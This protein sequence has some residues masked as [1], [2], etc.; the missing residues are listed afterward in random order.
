MSSFCLILL[1]W[2]ASPR[3][4]S[5]QDPNHVAVVVR[6]DEE[7]VISKCVAFDEEQISGYDA[8]RRS[9]LSVIAGF[10][11]QGGTMCQIDGVG[12]PADNCFCRC[13]G[14]QDC[15]YWSYW[16]QVGD[17]WE[18][19]RV[20]A[21]TYRVGDKQVEGWSWGPGTISQA[22]EPPKVTFEEVCDSL[23]RGE[24]A[25]PTEESTLPGGWLQYALFGGILGLFALALVYSQI[26]RD[27]A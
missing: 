6:F 4:L 15:I 8:L 2:L 11:A 23:E 18:Y 22:V 19:A 1:A 9:G 10:D 24:V 14:G 12:C 17:S 25:A 20:G 7:T 5:A 13:K 27:N 21:T 26:R 16:H 3:Q